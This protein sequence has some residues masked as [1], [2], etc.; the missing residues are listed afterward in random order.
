METIIQNKNRRI[1]RLFTNLPLMS[2]V[3]PYYAHTHTCYRTLTQL[4]SHTRNIF[5]EN[6][7]AF[8][9]VILKSN[10]L[11]L[12]ALQCIS[13]ISPKKYELLTSLFKFYVMEV[14]SF[15]DIIIIL[16]T[17]EEHPYWILSII[18]WAIHFDDDDNHTGIS[19]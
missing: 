1:K 17:W 14:T 5:Y 9:T 15:K 2:I 3:L 19:K 6:K 12:R 7:N 16:K 13:E 11:K 18:D 4:N 8:L 10:R